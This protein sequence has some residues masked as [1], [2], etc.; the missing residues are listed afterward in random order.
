MVFKPGEKAK[1]VC[2]ARH[3]DKALHTYIGQEVT[4]TSELMPMFA[5]G[6][7]MGYE[8]RASDGF[9]MACIPEVL[10]RPIPRRKEPLGNW[11]EVP[12]FHRITAPKKAPVEPVTCG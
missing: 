3:C 7:K 6:G 8:I 10:E 1:L 12:Y 11:L 4:V 5:I 9:M 2:P